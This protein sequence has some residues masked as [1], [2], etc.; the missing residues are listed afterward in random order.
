VALLV[1][2]GLASAA[3]PGVLAS[4]VPAAE[5]MRPDST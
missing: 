4:R 1:V 3:A 2:A 5:A